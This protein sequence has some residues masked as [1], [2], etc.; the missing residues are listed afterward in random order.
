MESRLD[1]LDNFEGVW[2]SIRVS[3]G[4]DTQVNFV[5][6]GVFSEGDVGA[7]NGIRR[8]HFDVL[9]LGV[10][11]ARTLENSI[12]VVQLIHIFLIMTSYFIQTH[13]FRTPN[14]L[15]MQIACLLASESLN[16]FTRQFIS[17]FERQY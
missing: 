4:S 8:S 1:L 7:E 2:F 6:T 5:V 9:D 10:E 14:K 11:A 17:I 12:H 16:H 3:V 13:K 15:I